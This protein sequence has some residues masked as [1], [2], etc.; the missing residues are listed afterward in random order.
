MPEKSSWEAYRVERE[1]YVKS[2]S[3]AIRKLREKQ[4]TER[5]NLYHRQKGSRN[6]LFS[7]DWKGRGM[8]LNQ[9]RSIF[10]FVHRRGQLE[11]RE[12]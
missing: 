3:E 5:E 6:E 2:K 11:L 12:H 8:E 10:A 9:L 7:Q 4:R 1:A